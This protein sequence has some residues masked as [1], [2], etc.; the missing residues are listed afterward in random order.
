MRALVLLLLAAGCHE[1]PE[2]AD[3]DPR[4][5]TLVVAAVADLGP[6]LYPVYETTTDGDV[7]AAIHYPMLRTRFDCRLQYAPGLVEAWRF[8]DDQRSIAITLRD[9]ITWSDGTPVTADDVAFTYE[10]VRDPVVASVRGTAIRHLDPESPRVV[11]ATHYEVHAKGTV[12]PETLLRAAT[13]PPTPRH[14]LKDGDRAS[15]RGLP[16]ARDPLATGPWRLGRREPGQFFELVPNPAFTGPA[17]MRPRLQR[18]LFRVLPER[19]TSLIEVQSGGVDLVSGLT[20]ED[21]EGLSA[22]E[23]HL[24]LVARGKRATD[25]LAWNL[26]DPRLSDRRVR[27]ALALAVDFDRIIAQ[28]FGTPDGRVWAMRALGTNTPLLCDLRDETLSPL[29]FDPDGARELL[30]EAGWSDTDGDGTLDRDGAPFVLRLLANRESTRRQKAAVYLQSAWEAVGVHTEIEV[31][32][33]R[34]YVERLHERAFEGAL[35]GWSSSLTPSL[36]MWHTD[37]ETFPSP[38]NFSAYS[39]SEVD[40]LIERVEGT[41]DPAAALALR[42]EAQRRIYGDQPALFLWWM[43][44]IVAVHERFEDPTITPLSALDH[45]EG[46]HTAASPGH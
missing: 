30:A 3:D 11:D 29:P 23:S 1:A 42:Q 31:L 28:M 21:V 12:D 40:A 13:L 35:I 8:S 2:P 46:W 41:P 44:E 14:A 18:V 25:F 22:V 34:A 4:R 39:D 45:L 19:A 38:R 33:G 7:L 10:L 36:E 5:E 24:R 6:L 26:N 37:T 16:E 17:S 43:D 20:V 27:R 32:D 15:L 9:D